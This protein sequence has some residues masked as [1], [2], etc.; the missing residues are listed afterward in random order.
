LGAICF[1][2]SSGAAGDMILGSLLDLDV[3]LDEVVRGL[4]SS[5]LDDFE[6]EFDREEYVKGITAGRLRVNISE[7]HH[8]RNLHDIE[9]IINK[10]DYPQRVKDRALTV[11]RRL[12]DA[13]AAVHRIP[14]DKVHFHEVGAVDA[15]V[16]ILGTAIA[17][18]KLH[19][20]EIY[21]GQIAIGHGTVTCAHG[22]LPVPTPATVELLIGYPVV[23]LNVEHELTTPTGAAILTT[24]TQGDWSG[25]PMIIRKVG[26][27]RG[28]LEIDG[29]PSIFRTFLTT[30]GLPGIKG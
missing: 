8:H 13:E 23:R 1:D 17:L 14:V 26:S 9:T 5:G 12:A 27:S 3:P 4:R 7:I 25:K 22:R 10:G 16:D 2:P 24:L 30:M 18:E 20:D 19:V 21:C 6:L 29:V 11:F 15:V 28:S